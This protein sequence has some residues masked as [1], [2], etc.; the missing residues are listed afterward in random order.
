MKKLIIWCAVLCSF[1]K[2]YAQDSVVD[3]RVAV[4]TSVRV[5]TQ[6]NIS[7]QDTKDEERVKNIS[8]TFPADQ[9]DK[10]ALSN[11]YGSMVIKVWDRREVKIDIAIRANSGG[12][13]QNLMDQVNI[14][15]G[16][17][18][19]VISCKTDIDNGRHWGGRNNT[20]SL[21]IDYVV[22][23][24]AANALTLSQE[25]GNILMGDHSGPVSANV[26]YGN[27]DAGNL[28]STNNYISVQYGKTN[29][30][31]V[32]RAT[33]KQQ[34]GAGLMV[35]TAGTLDIDA[36]YVNVTV[37]TIRGNALI[38]QQYGSGL[39]I[40]SVNNLDLDAQ[41]VNVNIANIKGNATVK[42]EYNSLTIGTVGKLNLRAEYAGVNIGSL[43]GDGNFRM[44]YNKFIVGAVG[45]GCKSLLV[46][47]EYVD[48]NL[49][50]VDGYNA[51]FTVQ[52][53][54]G[55][56]KSDSRLGGSVNVRGGDED[57]S[58]KNYSGK[59]GSGGSAIV[60]VKSEYGSVVF[61]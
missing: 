60:R 49:G 1:G 61:K 2:V 53:S 9:N 32:N 57:S 39:K 41:Y 20:R 58:T 14:T 37:N 22:Y 42:Q 29:I 33:I 15:A 47:V 51:D 17:S 56:F 12:D 34:Y 8:K 6:V 30:E 19:D 55:S 26:Q 31:A 36:Q 43:R 27:L 13:T 10:I 3:S 18:G 54:Y 25:F 46:D 24:P 4:N 59:I 7:D 5:H 48:V 16:K 45:A 38:K 23:L 28:S 21:K 11:Q 50:F 52:K 44:S 40:G 35:G